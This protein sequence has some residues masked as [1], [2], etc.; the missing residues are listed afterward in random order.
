VGDLTGFAAATWMRGVPYVQIPTTLLAQVDA[1]VGGKTAVD[2]PQGKNLAGAFH[3]PALALLDVETLNTLPPREFRCGMAEVVKY[4]AIYDRTFFDRLR[5]PPR[6]EALEDI[7]AECCRL[8]AGAVTRDER[9]TGERALLNFGHTFGHALETLGGYE[10]YRHGEAVAIG[11]ALAA[12]AGT[13]LGVTP[14]GCLPALRAALAA[15]GLDSVCPLPPSAL[16]PAMRLDKKNSGGGLRLVL[17]RALGDAF[18]HSIAEE[19]LTALLERMDA[20]WTQR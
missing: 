4:G 11:M 15:H 7:V 18:V 8:K 1:S 2:L 10:T 5:T 12:E 9:D 3:Q 14:P 6:P 16:L 20:A 13:L 19:A 17:L